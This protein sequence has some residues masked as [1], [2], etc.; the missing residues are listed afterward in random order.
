MS[1][2][3]QQPDVQWVFPPEKNR[4]GRVWLIVGLVAA[5]LL[6]AGALAFFLIPRDGAPT[7][8]SSSSPSPSASATRTPTPTPTRTPTPVPTVSPAPLPSA[9]VTEPPAPVEPGTGE[10]GAAVAGRLADASIGLDLIANGA[11]ALPIID[12]LELDAQQLADTVAPAALDAQ[13]RESV[14][15][16]ASSLRALRDVVNASEDVSSAV[17]TAAANVQQLKAIAGV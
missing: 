14:N 13:W 17:S 9:P 3:E 12:Q 4:A 11:D 8:G 10:F 1:M 15:A 7:P 6:I 16:Y 2:N 5:V